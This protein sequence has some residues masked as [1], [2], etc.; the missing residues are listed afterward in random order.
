MNME[1]ILLFAGCVAAYLWTE[2]KALASTQPMTRGIAL[3]LCALSLAIW[4]Y[5]TADL[6]IVFPTVVL[7]EWLEPL[8]TVDETME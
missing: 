6:K 2:R 3:A 7:E 4:A 5:C 1:Q 8:I